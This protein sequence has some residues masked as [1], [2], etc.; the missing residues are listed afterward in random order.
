MASNPKV[1]LSHTSA[2]K[3]TFARQLAKGI[4]E[5]G[6]EV[7]YYER[8]IRPAEKLLDRI[9]SGIRDSTHFLLLISVR[10]LRSKW[11]NVELDYALNLELLGNGPVILPVVIGN[12]KAEAMPL[13]IMG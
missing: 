12:V 10:S 6:I 11:V 9:Q 5:A 8:S 4:R 1:F 7:F 2:D 3:P 13:G